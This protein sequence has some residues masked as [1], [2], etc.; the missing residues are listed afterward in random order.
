M[1]CRIAKA[2]QARRQAE[3]IPGPPAEEPPPPPPPE[4]NPPP[5]PPPPIDAAAPPLSF[6]MPGST[7]FHGVSSST[8][9]HVPQVVM[10]LSCLGKDLLP[11][12][13][14]FPQCDSITNNGV[15]YRLK[16]ISRR[17][18]PRPNR[19]IAQRLAAARSL[20]RLQCS[21]A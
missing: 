7:T 19:S 12:A 14:T 18:Q 3:G 20:L 4:D 2:H 9:H 6:S 15:L 11:F 8:A 1:L 13:S 17:H 10:S 16:N 21:S 5:P